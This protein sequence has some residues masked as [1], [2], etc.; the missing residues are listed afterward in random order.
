VIADFNEAYGRRTGAGFSRFGRNK[1]SLSKS[2]PL[3]E[4]ARGFATNAC[5]VGAKPIA[6]HPSS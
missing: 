3:G 5:A 2:K 4:A 1:L 6:P